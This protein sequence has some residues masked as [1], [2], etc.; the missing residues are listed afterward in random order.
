MNLLVEIEQFDQSEIASVF[1]VAPFEYGSDR[2]FAGLGGWEHL[3]ANRNGRESKLLRPEIPCR[4]QQVQNTALEQLVYQV[5]VFFLVSWADYMNNINTYLISCHGIT[6]AR[7]RALS[8]NEVLTLL[9]HTV[10]NFIG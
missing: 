5:F 7:N 1:Q 3:L 4:I 6:A 9:I 2:D 10:T 8:S